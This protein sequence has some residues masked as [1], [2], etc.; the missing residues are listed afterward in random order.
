MKSKYILFFLLIT[1]TS[2]SQWTQIVYN[3][4]WAMQVVKNQIVREASSEALIYEYQQENEL[5]DDINK[6]M[7]QVVIIHNHIFNQLSNV[8][9]Y[10]SQGR[11]LKSFVYEFNQIIKLFGETKTALRK[12]PKYWILLRKDFENLYLYTIGIGAD[13]T[14]ILNKDSTKILLD[15]YERDEILSIL[16]KRVRNIRISLYRIKMQIEMY[17]SRSDIMNIPFLNNWIQTDKALVNNIVNRYN[18]FIK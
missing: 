4:E 6:K 2:Y 18:L 15:S 17:S 9:S 11:K 3:E 13:V 5:Y 16:L 10:F 12:Y 8:N 1:S 7:A 14:N